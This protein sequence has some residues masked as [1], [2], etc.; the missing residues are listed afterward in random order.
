MR[1]GCRSGIQL[2]HDLSCGTRLGRSVSS[3]TGAG[4]VTSAAPSKALRT[5]GPS[6][7]SGV[8]VR[9]RDQPRYAQKVNLNADQVSTVHRGMR[10]DVL[11][12][13]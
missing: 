10:G 7:H 6:S 9:I 3:G 1:A 11:D 8:L 5:S 2:E 12:G 4:K 13:A